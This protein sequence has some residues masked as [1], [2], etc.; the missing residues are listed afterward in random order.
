MSS[1]LKHAFRSLV[2]YA[3]QDAEAWKMLSF[4]TSV[5][6]V[7]IGVASYSGITLPQ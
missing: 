5:V 1:T 6:L 4:L 2:W 7:A 3:S